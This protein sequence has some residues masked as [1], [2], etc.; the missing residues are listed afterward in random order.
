MKLLI[1][2]AT[3]ATGQQLVRRG[4]DQQFLVT[5]FVRA[6]GKLAV[7]HPNLRVVTGDITRPETMRAA[8]PGQAA[9]LSALGVRHNRRHNTAL[10]DGTRAILAAME[11]HQVRR[12]ICETSMGVGSSKDEGS[13]LFERIFAPLFLGHSMADKE[14]QE[15]LIWRSALAWT[16]VRPA[17]L[18]NGPRTGDYKVGLSLASTRIKNRIS[19]ADVADF[20]LRQLTTDAFVRKAVN[21]SY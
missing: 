7:Q 11:Q 20:M 3:G 2:G 17:G 13:W 18:T 8:M 15:A 5:A 4:L 6:A 12:F 1:F 14:R 9:A 19:R 21:I 10:P 16:I